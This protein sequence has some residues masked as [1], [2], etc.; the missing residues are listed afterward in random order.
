M[1][2][3]YVS[4]STLLVHVQRR[5]HPTSTFLFAQTSNAK[6]AQRRQKNDANPGRCELRIVAVLPLC[7]VSAAPIPLRNGICMRSF[8]EPW[9]S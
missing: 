6:Y 8:G 7:A 4:C 2:H 3:T 1:S 5:H 9:N